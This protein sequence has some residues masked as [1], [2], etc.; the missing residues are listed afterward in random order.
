M[1]EHGM[2]GRPH[3]TTC[4]GPVANTSATM[5]S[6]RYERARAGRSDPR[7]PEAAVPLEHADAYRPVRRR[8]GEH[9]VNLGHVLAHVR[10]R[11]A[12]RRCHAAT[13]AGGSSASKSL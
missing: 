7:S 4:G 10:G 11:A 9:P 3:V 8:L 12:Y 6:M 13:S 5:M 1:R 2:A